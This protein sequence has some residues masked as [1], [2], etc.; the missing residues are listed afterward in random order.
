MLELGSVDLMIVEDVKC[1][2]AGHSQPGHIQGFPPDVDAAIKTWKL[3][4]AK[5]LEVQIKRS[6]YFPP[7]AEAH[8]HTGADR[9]LQVCLNSEDY[10]QYM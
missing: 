2:H 5:E 1:C 6:G 8:K 10:Q 4:K 9:T 3:Q 7:G